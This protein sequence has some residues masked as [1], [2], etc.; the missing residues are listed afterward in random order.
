MITPGLFDPPQAGA[1]ALGATELLLVADVPGVL[2]D[3]IVLP[4]LAPDDVRRLVA[5]GAAS[6]GMLA[7]LEAA[8][9]A[10]AGGVPRVRI[11]DLAAFED[12]T[13]GTVVRPG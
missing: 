9:A 4:A 2:E 12:P 8:A 11:G 7:K 6:A 5:S 10:L 1:A 3:G 13:R